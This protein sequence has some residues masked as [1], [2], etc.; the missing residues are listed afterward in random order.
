MDKLYVY[1]LRAKTFSFLHHQF[2]LSTVASSTHK[3]NLGSSILKN[4]PLI[5]SH[6][7]FQL[8]TPVSAPC[9]RTILLKDCLFKKSRLVIPDEYKL[10]WS[11][12]NSIT[13]RTICKS[14]PKIFFLSYLIRSLVWNEKALWQ[15]RYCKSL[16][17]LLIQLIQ[18]L[19]FGFSQDWSLINHSIKDAFVL[20]P[21]IL[22]SVR[23]C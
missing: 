18:N 13:C 9:C 22:I 10:V 7:T 11:W 8:L 6:I 3:H 21:I 20:C 4:K 5:T 19:P 12:D 15:E 14:E 16:S 23:D 1:A 2:F 17:Y